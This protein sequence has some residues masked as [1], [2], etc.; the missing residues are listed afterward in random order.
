M[1]IVDTCRHRARTRTRALGAAAVVIVAFAVTGC[2]TADAGEGP[3]E[4]KSFAFSGK[5]LTID[6]RNSEVELVPADVR[7]VEVERQVDGWVFMG[8]GPDP[9]WEMKDGTLTVGV[10]C[11]AVSSDCEAR[12]SVKVPRG[13]AVTVRGDNG[14]VRATG[15]DTALT[16]QSD[17]GEV[18]VRDSS[19]PLKLVSD[20]GE[21]NG[22]R[23]ASG[24]VSVR[25]DNGSVKL[26]FVKDPD[27]VD[28]VSDNGAITIEVPGSGAYD[29]TASAEN[30]D[31]SVDVKQDPRSPHVIKTRS[32][33]GEV[34]VRAN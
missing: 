17:N 11:D 32:D 18:T 2:G 24:N 30:G 8:S 29:V 13:V 34:V 12:H 5:S 28:G 7:S 1:I 14:S 23:I 15:F 26:A 20:N 31:T 3:V 6:A 25:S 10:T 27:L 33:N 4:R 19:G 22:E 21:I 9:V 16:L